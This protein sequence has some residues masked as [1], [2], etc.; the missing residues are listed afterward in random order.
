M[1]IFSA[2]EDLQR[3]TLKAILGSLRKLEYF[4]RLRDKE[5]GYFHWGLS[6]LHG[7]LRAK[8]ALADAHRTELSSLLA[9]PLRQLENDVQRS[10]DEAGVQEAEYL[11]RLS[12]NVAH[13]L[14]PNPGAGSGRHLSSVLHALSSLRK[15]RKSGANPPT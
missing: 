13:L 9:T 11:E 3:T 4:A 8:R 14:P 5:G 2:L 6:R 1:P 12:N 7:E 15:S 10:S